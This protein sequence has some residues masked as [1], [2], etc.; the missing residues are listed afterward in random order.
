M[1]ELNVIYLLSVNGSCDRG[2][3][4]S[5]QVVGL[6]MGARKRVRYLMEMRYSLDFVADMRRVVDR[7]IASEKVVGVE[8]GSGSGSGKEGVGQEEE[9]PRTRRNHWVGVERYWITGLAR[10]HPMNTT[11]IAW[12][13]RRGDGSASF[14]REYLTC[15]HCR[16]ETSRETRR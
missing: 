9:K 6:S 2:R 11:I 4:A 13:S 8:V 3:I 7:E 12:H 16:S 14:S 1:V 5:L 15:L 10:Q